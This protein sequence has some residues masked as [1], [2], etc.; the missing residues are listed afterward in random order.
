MPLS[1]KLLFKII[2]MLQVSIG[3]LWVKSCDGSGENR[4]KWYNRIAIKVGSFGF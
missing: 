1:P 2:G 4:G 3:G